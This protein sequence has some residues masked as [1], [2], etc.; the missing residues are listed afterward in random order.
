MSCMPPPVSS[1]VILTKS[2]GGNEVSD[3]YTFL[4]C[5]FIIFSYTYIGSC[6]FQFSYGQFS[7]DRC[8]SIAAT[9]VC[10]SKWSDYVIYMYI[11]YCILSSEITL[12]T[13]MQKYTQFCN[14]QCHTNMYVLIHRLVLRLPFPSCR[15]LQS[16]P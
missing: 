3:Y 11:I 12:Q 1:A 8:H 4:F 13:H 7:R 5:C 16:F 10:T 9:S 15:Y 2:V 14:G 6:H